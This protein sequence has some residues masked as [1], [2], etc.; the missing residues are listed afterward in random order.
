MHNNKLMAKIYSQNLRWNKSA[1]SRQKLKSPF[2][3]SR[4]NLVCKRLESFIQ[5]SFC[6]L[7]KSENSCCIAKYHS[8]HVE[9]NYLKFSAILK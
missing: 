3:I 9:N 8:V 1:G 4:Y 5:K 6:M 2:N 7:Q